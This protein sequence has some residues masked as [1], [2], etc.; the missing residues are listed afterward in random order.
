MDAAKWGDWIPHKTFEEEIYE[1]IFVG[2]E[3]RAGGRDLHD[4]MAAAAGKSPMLASRHSTSTTS[5]RP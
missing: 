2:G 3:A 1:S 4:Q 5:T